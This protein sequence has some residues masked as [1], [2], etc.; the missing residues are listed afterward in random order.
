[1]SVSSF[2][3]N[4]NINTNINMAV[5]GPGSGVILNGEEGEDEGAHH[6]AA[7]NSPSSRRLH[8]PFSQSQLSLALS[9][10]KS[11]PATLSTRGISFCY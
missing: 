10:Q 1:L 3:R 6:D 11:K 2:V 5:T 7:G 9:I 4:I 8:L